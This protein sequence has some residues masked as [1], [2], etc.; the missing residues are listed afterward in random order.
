MN[1]G[2]G[3][4]GGTIFKMDTDGS[5]YSVL[6][7]FNAIEDG[8]W[9]LAGLILNSNILYGTTSYFGSA[10]RGT[11]FKIHTNGTS[12]TVIKNFTVDT[13]GVFPCSGLVASGSTFYGTTSNG[14]QNSDQG[15]VFKINTDGKGYSQLKSFNGNDGEYPTT[16]LIASGTMLY[17]TTEMGGTL[18]QGT[19]FVINTNGSGHNILKNF[20]AA[21]AGGYFPL[22]GLTL[23]SSVLYGT[24]LYGGLTGNGTIFV[25][26]TNG[27]Y[28]LLKT[29]AT[30]DGTQ[31][32][33]DL[34]LSRSTL[35]GTASAGATF[36]Y[37]SVF[38]MNTDGSGYTILRLFAYSDGT[39]PK[40]GLTLSGGTLYG[41]TSEGGDGGGTVFKINTDGSGFAV[42]KSFTDMGASPQVALV[43]SDGILYGTTAAGGALNCGTIFKLRT[44]GT[45]F[46][47]IKDFADSYGRAPVG[48]MI[49]SEGTLYGTT[50]EG[51]TTGN[52]TIFR[53]SLETITPPP[54][55]ISRSASKVIVTWP[56][57]ATRDFVL[58]ATTNIQANVWSM[59]SPSPVVLDG[60]YVV[61]NN[62]SDSA[63]LFRLRY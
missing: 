37:G 61:T 41:T 47:V 46:A 55:S 11:V 1:Y 38:K 20:S 51:G 48:K 21:N 52:G 6:K 12:Y 19:A 50:R 58:E 35:Y 33:G 53:L 36:N 43:L 32:S 62:I 30:S 45:D 57:N 49:L 24:T 2:A 18:Q 22:S 26:G 34:V 16:S 13:D 42:L 14:G 29:F 31:P 39:N 4:G 3:S 54:L 23:N 27:S 10:N 56:T 44:N 60:E 63:K 7:Y 17:G 9:P 8:A 25:L 5:G 28:G 59:V 40:A 15:S